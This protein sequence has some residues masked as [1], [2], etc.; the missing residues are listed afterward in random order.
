MSS[1]QIAFYLLREINQIKGMF[2]YKYQNR[3]QIIYCTCCYLTGRCTLPSS[4]LRQWK[5]TLLSTP[6]KTCKNQLPTFPISNTLQ[7][8]ITMYS[9]EGIPWQ[10]SVATSDSQFPVELSLQSDHCLTFKIMLS[11]TYQLK[12]F[13]YTKL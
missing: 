6:K 11:H 4:H 2:S 9:I 1:S 8:R 3:L 7:F 10:R 12:I 13:D 5:V